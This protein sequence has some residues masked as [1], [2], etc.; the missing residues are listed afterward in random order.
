MRS[1]PPAYA[2]HGMHSHSS[3]HTAC[4]A[5]GV[6]TASATHG[7]PTATTTTTTTTTTTPTLGER[8]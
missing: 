3:S 7:V 5:H 8:R 2:P 4:A 6:S 1:N